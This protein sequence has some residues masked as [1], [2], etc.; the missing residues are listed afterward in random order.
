MNEQG[1]QN[2]KHT[3]MYNMYLYNNIQW[4]IEGGSGGPIH[5]CVYSHTRKRILF[6]KNDS[7]DGKQSH[8]K[9]VGNLTSRIRYVIIYI[10]AI[11]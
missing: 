2:N 6:D 11:I 7:A 10:E 1:E 4:H 3:Y 5:I 9:K 8:C